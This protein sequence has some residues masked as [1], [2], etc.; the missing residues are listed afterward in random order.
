MNEQKDFYQLEK[1]II[2]LKELIDKLQTS[3]DPKKEQE[4]AKLRKQIEK[5]WAKIVP[6]YI[7]LSF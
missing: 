7:V 6:L 2:E 5:E 1:R 3:D 4:I